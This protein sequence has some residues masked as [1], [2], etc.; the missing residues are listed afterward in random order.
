MAMKMKELISSLFLISNLNQ[1][2]DSLVGNVSTSGFNTSSH[3]DGQNSDSTVYGFGQCRGDLNSSD[4]KQCVAT[5]KAAFGDCNKI[6]AS[7]MLDGCLLRYDNHS[8]S[9]NFN[10]STEYFHICNPGENSPSDFKI[11]IL[12][13][14][15][16]VLYKATK[17]PNIFAAEQDVAPNNSTVHIY[18]LAQC[19]RDLSTEDCEACLRFTLRQIG[20]YCSAG[21]IGLQMGSVNCYMRSELYPFFNRPIIS[22]SPLPSPLPSPTESPRVSKAKRSNVLWV[23]LGVA[24]TTVGL[25]AA[26]SLCKLIFSSRRKIWKR[27]SQMRGHEGEISLSATIPNREF[28]FKYQTLKGATSNFHAERK[29]G[30]G[31]FGSVFKGD[32]PDGREVAVKRLKIGSSQ[33]DIQF[34]NEVNLISR[35]QHR[36]LVKLLGCSVENSE[37]LLVY[38]YLQNSSLDN[39]IY[40]IE[41][42]HLLDWRQRY[43]II[44]GTARGL[45][46]LHEE[47]EIRIIHRDIKAS[48]IL[49]DNNHKPKI[50]DFGLA[51]LF[52]DDKTH[53]STKVAGT[54]GYMAPEYAYGGHLTEK[55]DVFSF[56]VLVL[57]IISGTKNQSS[58]QDTEFLIERTWKLYN[59]ER[60]LEVMDPTLEGSYSWEEGIMV[61]KI[62]LLCAQAAAALRPS[63]SRVVSMLTSEK[64][65]LPSPTS[66]PFVDLHNLGVPAPHNALGST[67]TSNTPPDIHSAA[68]D[69]SSGILEPR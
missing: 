10:E 5:A 20:S 9:N 50:T 47:S 69:P 4:C 7:I 34:F 8:F 44:V 45:A 61:I 28:I 62:G 63:M 22:P 33:G 24:A 26:I 55:A 14:L 15:R 25:V 66:P 21:A 58:A 27:I 1:V 41:K 42:R 37:R 57:E 51:K 30:E 43:E 60:A 64:E 38:E 18:S 54:L 40:D 12:A 3:D 31:G 32:L 35:V 2:L 53:V 6:S 48:N 11:T 56:G 49:L 36:N 52:E 68:A 13:M 17:A 19:W 16:K 67:A 65:H 23:T 46:Y 29:L 59:A 39:I